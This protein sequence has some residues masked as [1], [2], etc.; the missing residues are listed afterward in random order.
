MAPSNN[1]QKMHIAV[2][3]H[4]HQKP[5]LIEYVHTVSESITAAVNQ[6][7]AESAQHHLDNVRHIVMSA[8]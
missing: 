3:E 1:T 7:T 2:S 6:Q 4:V 8:A 5:R